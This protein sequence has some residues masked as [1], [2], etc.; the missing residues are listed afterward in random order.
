VAVNVTGII[1]LFLAGFLLFRGLPGVIEL[2]G[3]RGWQRVPGTVLGSG[4]AGYRIQA[5]G[6]HMGARVERAVFA[7]RYEVDGTTYTG[8]RA[9]FGT[10]LGF[11]MGLGGVA[12][13]HAGRYS[14]GEK[15]DVWVD[16]ADPSRTVLRRSATTSVLITAAGAACAI[17]GAI[18]LAGN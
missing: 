9:A 17:A 8:H 4:V 3:A 7:Y 15:V 10:P 16:P 13:A 11:G 14:P 1:L 2:L 5:T 6:G 18:S 12:S